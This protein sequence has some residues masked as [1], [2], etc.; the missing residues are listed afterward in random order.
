MYFPDEQQANASDPVL[1]SVDDQSTLVARA[2]EE[3]LEFDIRLQGE[4]QTVFFAV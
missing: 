1:S 3:G 2:G 4:N